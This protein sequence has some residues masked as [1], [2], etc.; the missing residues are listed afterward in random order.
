MCDLAELSI[1]LDWSSSLSGSQE[2]QLLLIEGIVIEN[3]YSLCN[4]GCQ[5]LL[6]FRR[7]GGPVNSSSK[8]D[9]DIGGRDSQLNDAAN[10]QVND[11]CAGT[12]AC[13]VRRNNQY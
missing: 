9:C 7:S 8:N 1:D 10:Q 13:G 12:G 4:K 11:L 3:F 2:R 5:Q 6:F